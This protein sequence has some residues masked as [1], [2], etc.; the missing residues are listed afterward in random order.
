MSGD[1]TGAIVLILSN[2]YKKSCNIGAISA[3]CFLFRA[4]Y[5]IAVLQLCW[6]ACHHFIA[7]DVFNIAVAAQVVM[8]TVS[9]FSVQFLVEMM[10]LYARTNFKYFLRMQV[11]CG[12][13]FA[14]GIGGGTSCA[15]YMYSN[16]GR[17][18]PFYVAEG[19]AALGFL[20]YTT[21]FLCRVGIPRSLKDFE[22]EHYP[23]TSSTTEL[24]SVVVN[25][26]PA[27]CTDEVRREGERVEAAQSRT[28]IH[29]QLATFLPLPRPEDAAAQMMNGPMTLSLRVNALLLDCGIATPSTDEN[30]V[31]RGRRLASE[32]GLQFENVLAVVQN[33]EL[34]MYGSLKS[35]ATVAARHDNVT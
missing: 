6:V 25:V 31:S 2:R 11:L 33:A 3:S 8:G 23:L 20:I 5:N 27:E 34:L 13:A 26:K 1:V 19:V 4:P 9:V 24:S 21:G 14:I 16:W 18:S 7:S 15:T 32:L 17:R 22:E 35:A 28:G 12:T 29:E 10:Q 30:L